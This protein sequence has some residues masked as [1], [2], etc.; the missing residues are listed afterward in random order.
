MFLLRFVHERRAPPV[1]TN[2]TESTTSPNCPDTSWKSIAVLELFSL[3]HA[4]AA[5]VYTAMH[6][7]VYRRLAV[8]Y[9]EYSVR[10]VRPI[11][12][13]ALIS[14]SRNK[15]NSH[16]TH[17]FAGNRRSLAAGFSFRLLTMRHI[18]CHRTNVYTQWEV[19]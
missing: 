16:F 6:H 1:R 9:S 7:G 18:I 12:C 3:A 4:L 10:Y 19:V 14:Y 17:F 8:L 5:H 2:A 11:L 13:V 15:K